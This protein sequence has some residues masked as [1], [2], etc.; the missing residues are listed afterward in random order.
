MLAVP[1][2]IAYIEKKTLSR[3]Q[4]TSSLGGTGPVLHTAYSFLHTTADKSYSPTKVATAERSRLVTATR[5]RA[6]CMLIDQVL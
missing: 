2:S 1:L 4:I 3:C 5:V 6:K